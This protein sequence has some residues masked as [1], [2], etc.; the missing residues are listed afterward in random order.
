MISLAAEKIQVLALQEKRTP[1][2]AAPLEPTEVF[3]LAA[4]CQTHLCPHFD[5]ANCGLAARI[6]QIL[7]A[8]VEQLPPCRIRPECRWFQQEG[9]TACR[10]C[11]RISTVNYGASE[12]M[13][14]VIRLAPGERN[15]DTHNLDPGL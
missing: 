6:V 5:G 11:P 7:P 13:Q 10:R 15:Y 4:A 3:R 9:A 8:V 2:L 12:I 1:R 14:T